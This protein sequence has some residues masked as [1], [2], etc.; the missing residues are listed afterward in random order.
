MPLLRN[1]SL[2][3]RNSIGSLS[4]E[5]YHNPKCSKSRASLALLRERGIEPVLRDYL[6]D[7]LSVSELID[8]AAKLGVDASYL[9]RHKDLGKYEKS[10]KGL[11]DSGIFK[12]LSKTPQLLVRPI[13]IKGS[14]AKI[15]IPPE[16]VLELL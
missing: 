6:N 15:G 9:V 14:K 12:L 1:E 11:S 2:T 13:A 3:F 7:A 8:V 16:D 5:L 10:L 4:M